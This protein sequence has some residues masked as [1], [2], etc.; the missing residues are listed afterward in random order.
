MLHNITDF[1]LIFGHEKLLLLDLFSELVFHGLRSVIIQDDLSED[2][3]V[4][5]VLLLVELQ[6]IFFALQV[7]LELLDFF[8]VHVLVVYLLQAPVLSYLP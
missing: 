4:L 1:P 7:L 6:Q 3:L 8:A 5:V 2:L